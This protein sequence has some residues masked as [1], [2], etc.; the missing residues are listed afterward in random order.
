MATL[1][2]YGSTLVAPNVGGANIVFNGRVGSTIATTSVNLDPANP[3]SFQN[4]RVELKA[5]FGV[6]VTTGVP[7]II[8]RILKFGRE[9]YNA[10]VGL[11]VSL[12]ITENFYLFNALALDGNTNLGVLNYQLAL[13]NVDPTSAFT[14]VGPLIFTATAIGG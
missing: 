1:I 8:V 2:N 3:A 13:E 7:R 10:E 14:V 12:G 11:E 9:I 4:A 6:Q 5:N